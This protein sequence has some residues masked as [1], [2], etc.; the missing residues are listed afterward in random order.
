ME[1]CR[2]VGAVAMPI[3][4]KED[5]QLKREKNYR[6]PLTVKLGTLLFKAYAD[7]SRK[8]NSSK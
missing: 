7:K 5:K 1:P 6:K 4:K 8:N 3:V 2:I